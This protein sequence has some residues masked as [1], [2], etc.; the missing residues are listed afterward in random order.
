M[1]RLSLR[2]LCI[3]V[4]F[5]P[6]LSAHINTQMIFAI[7]PVEIYDK[8]RLSVSMVEAPSPIFITKLYKFMYILFILITLRFWHAVLWFYVRFSVILR[9]GC[10]ISTRVYMCTG[11]WS[12][13]YKSVLIFRLTIFVSKLFSR[14]F[15]T[16]FPNIIVPE[17][18]YV[19]HIYYLL[20]RLLSLCFCP[21]SW[22]PIG[23][24]Q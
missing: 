24:G 18:Y 5:L 10:F 12:F 22:A 7:T 6:V 15:G 3:C 17:C 4:D 9:W 23:G 21:V 8:L 1:S 13:Q 20:S 11:R 2:T 16:F 19:S 14:L